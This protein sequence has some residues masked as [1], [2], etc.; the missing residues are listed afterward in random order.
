T[1]ANCA[2]R[3]G[4]LVPSS[5]PAEKATARQDQARQTSTGD[6]G[7]RSGEHDCDAQSRTCWPWKASTLLLV[8]D[9]PE[10]G[11]SDDKLTTTASCK[12]QKSAASQ[13]QAR[14]A[15]SRYRSGDNFAVER[16]ARVERWWR[17]A[18]N[19]IGADP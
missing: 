15:S 2:G 17:V 9:Y 1:C 4:D 10:T 12:G 16:K 13:D 5:P 11:K 8:V 14:E 3:S 7:K 19:D 18:A 6:G